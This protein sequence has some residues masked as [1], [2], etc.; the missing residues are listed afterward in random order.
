MAAAVLR[1][2]YDAYIQASFI[3]HDPSM[4]EQQAELY[5][6]FFDIE[7]YVQEQEVLKQS[8][9]LASHLQHSP[10]RQAGSKRLKDAY[11]RAAPRFATKDGKGVRKTHW[12][13]GSLL[14]LAE[15]AGLRDEYMWFVKGLN[16]AVH[17]GPMA[18]RFGPAFPIEHMGMHASMIVAR[19]AKLLT[20]NESLTISD[21][22]SKTLADLS[23]NLLDA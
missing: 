15:A 6:S 19:T 13:P 17:A 8:N 2:A 1:C 5:L 10:L 22:S 20:E 7:R 21:D 9:R 11:D 12:Y 3:V 16:S 4:R 14:T 18:I 23:A